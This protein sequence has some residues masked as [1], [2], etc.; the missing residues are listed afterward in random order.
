MRLKA[1]VQQ[2]M[3]RLCEDVGQHFPIPQTK[4]VTFGRKVLQH[5][6]DR[7]QHQ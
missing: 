6:N 5:R 2:G 7:E 3:N 1:K 4:Q